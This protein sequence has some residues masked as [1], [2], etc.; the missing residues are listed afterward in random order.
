MGGKRREH[1]RAVRHVLRQ[2]T[3]LVQGGAVGDQSIARNRA[4]SGF[5]PH[6]PAVGRRLSDG[7][8]RIRADGIN[9]F[10][11]RHRR[12]GATGRTARHMFRVSRVLCGT[13]CRGF[14]GGTHG[15]LVHIC[16][17]ENHSARL[18]QIL[19][20]LRRVGRHKV[21]QNFRGTGSEQSLRADIV[22][23]CNRHARKRSRK[24]SILD[25]FL[26]HR[27]LRQCT[28]PIYRHIAVILFILFFNLRKHSLRGFC[29]G[30]LPRPDCRRELCRGHFHYIHIHFCS[31]CIICGE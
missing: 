12:R 28:V 9:A 8:A 16:L 5:H 2:R 15:K 22:L 1:S 27:R 6:H 3:D 14:R 11:R 31:S 24:L 18:L 29:C 20:S 7:T 4:I 30:S 25:F 21:M 26:H 23:H 10:T 13:I 19:H 17:A